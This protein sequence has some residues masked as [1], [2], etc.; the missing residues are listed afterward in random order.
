M[1]LEKK[2]IVLFSP[3]YLSKGF[4]FVSFIS[5]IG[6]SSMMRY[7]PFK[8]SDLKSHIP[9]LSAQALQTIHLLTDDAL[10]KEKIKSN[11]LLK[12]SMSGQNL[13]V[14]LLRRTIR[15]LHEVFAEGIKTWGDVPWFHEIVHAET[16]KVTKSPCVFTS[17]PVKLSFKVEQDE[18]NGLQITTFVSIGS[19]T[20]NRKDFRRTVFLLEHQS[21]YFLLSYNDYLILEWL[22][23][24]DPSQ[25]A[26]LPKEF[27]LNIVWKL[28]DKGYPLD[29][30]DCFKPTIINTKPEPLVLVNEISHAFLQFIPS[31]NYEGIKIEGNYTPQMEVQRQGDIYLVHRDKEAESFLVNSIRSKHVSFAQ[32]FNG[33][34]FIK[35]EDARKKN[36]FFNLYQEWLENGVQILGLDMLEHFRYS[37]HKI[38][39]ELIFMSNEGG[40]TTLK[41]LI[42]FGPTQ[43]RLKEL[44]KILLASQKSILLQDDTIGVLTDDW[45]SD[46]AMIIK[47]AKIADKEEIKVSNWLLYSLT[48]EK[49]KWNNPEDVSSDVWRSMWD[50]WQQTEKEI[51]P[52]PASVRASLRPYQQKGFEW[53][54]LLSMIEAGACLSDEM[55]LGKTLQ[56]ITFLAWLKNKN[57]DARCIIICPASLI[58]NWKS[59][60]EKFAPSLKTRIFTGGEKELADFFKTDESIL[61]T[62]YGLARTQA[63]L[64]ELQVWHAVIVDE[65]HNI[66]NPTA[67]ITK[68]VY[69]LKGMNRIALSGTPVMNNTFDLYSQLEFLL[70]GLLG[71][72]EFFRK[73]YAN[74]ID[75][76]ANQEKTKELSKITSPF[77]LR[78][79]KKQVAKDLPDKTESILWCNM[80]ESQRSIYQEIKNSIR[81]SVFLNI[82]K[83]GLKNSKIGILA[84]I[85]KL[86]QICCSPDLLQEYSDFK[87]T[88]S[89]KIKILMDEISEQ[90]E[91]SKIL[92]FSQYKQMLHLVGKKLRTSGIRYYHFDGDTPVPERQEMVDAFNKDDDASRVFLISL[93]A[94][95]TGLNL[96]AADYVFLVDPWWNTAVENQAIDRTHRIGQTK[97]V[98]AYRMICKD[99]IEERIIQLQQ[100]KRELS[101]ELVRAEDSFVKDLTEEDVDFLFS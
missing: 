48:S 7:E 68:A 97:H 66:K 83:D 73:E 82:Q 79:T 36:W 51:I 61:I 77:I 86:K 39:T 25:Y 44:Q 56:T 23:E 31:W 78:R 95:N 75:K 99:T 64:L 30:N 6:K 80:E 14:L 88:D 40:I 19:Q 34:F 67:Q 5:V 89:I 11:K 74:P 21:Q 12:T 81:D 26:F 16:K 9:G 17:F 4:G 96:T 100:K 90:I 8:P 20:Y 76:D 38:E 49:I 37:Q 43:V 98:M 92:V 91:H 60:C 3:K 45:L 54:C 93:K 57:Q 15:Y 24:T 62:G 69:R 84:G 65:S 55:G 71:S 52:A 35:F 94:G 42:R 70:P 13:D 87:F 101:D 63:D 50:D 27:L 1:S 59:E 18:E 47:H 72:Q 85:T 41:C 28:E 29:R 58:Y 32:Q 46:Y 2:A 10:S 53:L 33:N 22:K